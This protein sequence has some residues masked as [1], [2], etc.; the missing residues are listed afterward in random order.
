MSPSDLKKTVCYVRVSTAGQ[1]YASQE[2]ALA[3]YCRGR[4]WSEGD[5]TIIRELASGSGKK[6]PELD[7]IMRAVQAGEIKTVVV[8]KLDRL[9][10]SV[11]HLSWVVN[12]FLRMKVAL[13]CTSQ[14]IDTSSDSAMTRFQV[15]ALSG[16]AE[17]EKDI[18]RER[19]RAGQAAARKRGSIL[20]RPNSSEQHRKRAEQLRG[21]GWGYERIAKKLGISETSAFRLCHQVKGPK[22][23]RAFR[24]AAR[25]R[26]FR[27]SKLS[28]QKQGALALEA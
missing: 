22:P 6:W 27:V 9:G 18:I 24:T 7:R 3:V 8:Y 4:G 14:G 1:N 2:E 28:P 5:Y 20:G 23:V 13:I 11:A 19:V 12:E 25:P 15:N 21:Q 26:K 16:F 17:M 10:R